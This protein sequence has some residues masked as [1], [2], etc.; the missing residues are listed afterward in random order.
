MDH[1]VAI[2]VPALNEYKTI[3]KVVQSAA[4]YGEVIVV[5][6]G[7]SDETSR[8]AN[9]SGALVVNHEFTQ[10][11]DSALN[12]GI[13]M[14]IDLGFEF[15]ITID[16]DGQHN[17]DLLK[18]FIAELSNGADVV[19]GIRSEMQRISEKIFGYVAKAL[20]NIDD[21]LCGIKGYNLKAMN[22]IGKFSTYQS[23][24]TEF[25]IRAAASKLKII[26]VPIQVTKRIGISRFGTGLASEFKIFAAMFR[27]ILKN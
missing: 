25:S 17:P 22:K 1:A 24:G 9:E 5:N 11:Y 16:A 10:G 27:G 2:I 19:V 4:Q 3:T 23:I 7:S 21:P 6:D 15:A 12:S 13:K 20:W 26:N 14:A 8:L 18:L